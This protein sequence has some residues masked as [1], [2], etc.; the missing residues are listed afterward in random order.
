MLRTNFLA[1]VKSGSEPGL[2]E[3]LQEQSIVGF[4]AR[5]QMCMCTCV[6]GVLL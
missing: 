5:M 6:S 4:H 1:K 3:E 2:K